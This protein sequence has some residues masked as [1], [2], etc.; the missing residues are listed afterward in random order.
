VTRTE[1]QQNVT[2]LG[3]LRDEAEQ[4]K[5][6]AREDGRPLYRVATE[7]IREYLERRERE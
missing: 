4:L 3:V 1:Y 6:L 2:A 7:A 5:E